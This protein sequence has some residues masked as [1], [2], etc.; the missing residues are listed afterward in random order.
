VLKGSLVN[1]RAVEPDDYRLLW[2]WVNDPD[3]MVYWGRPGN[4]ESLPEVARLEELQSA[5]GTSRKYIIETHEALPIGQIDYYDLNWQARSA[6]TSIMIAD[7]Q[8]WGGGYGTDS[9]RTLLTYLF[10]QMGLHRISLSA[11]VTNE[12]AIRSYEKNG[13]QVEGTLREWAYFNGEW[14]DGVMMS[15]LESD[16]KL[17]RSRTPSA[18]TGREA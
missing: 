17:I 4:T 15:V 13:F 18:P 9:M 8:Y 1:L 10:T 14:V 11:H 5:R 6:W 12:R 16:F 3:V 7:P 2:H